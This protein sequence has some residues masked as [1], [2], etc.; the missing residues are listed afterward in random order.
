MTRALAGVCARALH[1]QTL[2]PDPAVH[3]ALANSK[4]KCREVL[5]EI[6]ARRRGEI[7]ALLRCEAQ[8]DRPNAADRPFAERQ[9]G[10]TLDDGTQVLEQLHG[11][12]AIGLDRIDRQ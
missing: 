4:V 1:R 10:F 5:N 2:A 8:L 9:I 6:D 7:F 11:A 12:E 3:T